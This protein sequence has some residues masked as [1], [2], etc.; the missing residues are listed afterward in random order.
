MGGDGRG[1][2]KGALGTIAGKTDRNLK[3]D[4]L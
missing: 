1:K 3:Q 2:L 4:V